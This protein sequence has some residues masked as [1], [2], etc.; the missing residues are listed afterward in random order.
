MTIHDLS[1]WHES[2]PQRLRI[3]RRTNWQIRIRLAQRYLTPSDTIRHELIQRFHL[4][5]HRVLATPLA[6][7][8]IFQPASHPTPR[9]VLFV[10]TRESR[11]NLQLFDSI[12][13]HF[14]DIPFL[15]IG[16]DPHDT[17]TYRIHNTHI[18]RDVSDPQLAALYQNAWAL[19]FPSRYEGFGLPILEAMQS[20]CPVLAADTALNRE[21]FH[22]AATLLPP[23]HPQPWIATLQSWL[24]SPSLWTQQR[25]YSIHFAARFSWTQTALATIDAYHQ[26]LA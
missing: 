3:R 5:Q 9:H 1:P 7:S 20:G 10:G 21:L 2:S 25:L 23:D 26:A 13:Q 24:D 18:L 15:A 11:K 12:A 6:A 16:R 17:P 8:R 4:P 14:P 22:P 19:L